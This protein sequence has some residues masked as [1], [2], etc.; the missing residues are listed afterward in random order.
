MHS[1]DD[2]LPSVPFHS[3]TRKTVEP[4]VWHLDIRIDGG[5]DVLKTASQDDRESGAEPGQ[6]FEFLR[7][8]RR[9]LI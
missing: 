4:L 9:I 5:C 7:D 3:G 1:P 2:Q 8:N 6:F